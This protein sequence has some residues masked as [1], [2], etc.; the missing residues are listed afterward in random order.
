[1]RSIKRSGRSPT[2]ASLGSS[3]AARAPKPGASLS[4]CSASRIGTV[5]QALLEHVERSFEQPDVQLAP[6]GSG[7]QYY[8]W[9]P[10]WQ[11]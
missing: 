3:T 6:N 11:L 10:C 9:M 4:R 5:W 2:I 1:M 7:W 8:K